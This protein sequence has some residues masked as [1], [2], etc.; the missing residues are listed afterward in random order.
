MK[1]IKNALIKI[2]KV[3]FYDEQYLKNQD[4]REL[5]KKIGPWHI[6]IRP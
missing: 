3:M 5:R 1:Y 4:F 2:L 6:Y